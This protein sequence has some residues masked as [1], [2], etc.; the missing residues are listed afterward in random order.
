[1]LLEASNTNFWEQ[2]TDSGRSGLM[3]VYRLYIINTVANPFIYAFLD[4]RFA[5]EIKKFCKPCKKL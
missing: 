2:F 1:M 4:K 5:K 3:F